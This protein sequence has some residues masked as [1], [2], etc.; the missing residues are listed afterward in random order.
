[1]TAWV[2]VSA[3]G[4]QVE[5]IVCTPGLQTSHTSASTSAQLYISPQAIDPT[6]YIQDI[7]HVAAKHLVLLRVKRNLRLL[8]PLLPLVT[9]QCIGILGAD[10]L[11]SPT[12]CTIWHCGVP[13]SQVVIVVLHNTGIQGPIAHASC[14]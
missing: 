9:Q 8:V 5:H 7:D 6:T 14:S 11:P 10:H 4:P 2:L 3:V 1:V 12:T 13:G